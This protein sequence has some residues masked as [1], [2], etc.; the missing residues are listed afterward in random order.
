MELRLNEEDSLRRSERLKVILS[1]LLIPS[2][3]YD[4]KSFLTLSVETLPIK[5]NSDATDIAT[6]LDVLELIDEKLSITSAE[7][8]AACLECRC[9]FYYRGRG[10]TSFLE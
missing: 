6:L 8:I 3:F 7:E 10:R 9:W 1:L 5:R 2:G 4:R